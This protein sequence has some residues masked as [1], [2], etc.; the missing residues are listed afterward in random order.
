MT[1]QGD[2]LIYCVETYKN[3]KH[4]TGRQVAEL[5]TRYDVWDYVYS[6][7]EALHTTG[8]NYKSWRTSTYISR[9]ENPLWLKV[10]VRNCT[11]PHLYLHIK[12]K[13]ICR[14]N[15]LEP[16]GRF[17]PCLKRAQLPLHSPLLGY[18]AC[19]K[20][21]DG[22]IEACIVNQRHEPRRNPMR[23]PCTCDASVVTSL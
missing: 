13:S 23:S 20:C 18:D 12:C 22:K 6:C 9:P 19:H 14:K 17:F 7:Y 8:A 21:F 15:R 11:F 2:F 5:F 16:S 3:A 1:R 10:A 4:L